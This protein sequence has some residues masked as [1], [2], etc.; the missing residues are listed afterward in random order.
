MAPEPQGPQ[1]VFADKLRFLS[2]GAH[3][4][5]PDAPVECVE[6]HFAC[7]FLTPRHA[8]KLRKPVRCGGVDTRELHARRQPRE[9]RTAGGSS[10]GC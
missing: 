7:V 1:P 9:S 10:T 4:G 3:L 5:E 8:W 2:D 6:T